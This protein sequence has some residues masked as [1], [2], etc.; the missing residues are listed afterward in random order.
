MD[1]SDPVS[2]N[3]DF[4]VIGIGLEDKGTPAGA[5]EAGTEIIPG[6][7]QQY[8]VSY[9]YSGKP[10]RKLPFSTWRHWCFLTFS[11]YEIWPIRFLRTPWSCTLTTSWS[12]WVPY[13]IL[14]QP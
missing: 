3:G 11:T 2:S 7:R 13:P 9:E 14:L 10:I 1:P 6:Q 5:R 12:I 4:G 8:L